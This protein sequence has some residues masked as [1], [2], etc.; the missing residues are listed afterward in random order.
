MNF[1]MEEYRELVER[2]H[3]TMAKSR[4]LAEVR[5]SSDTWTLHD[6]VGHL[7]DSASNNHQRF[8]RLSLADNLEFPGYDAEEWKAASSGYPADYRL[9]VE[10]SLAYNRYLLSLIA[11][12]DETKLGRV[13]HS[14]DGDKTLDFLVRDYFRHLQ[15]HV[16]LFDERL[17]E[18]KNR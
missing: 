1:P 15:W 8:V 13:W 11:S 3:R 17:A 18:I 16:D 12:L 2:F 7:V 9:L 10:L 4:R 14:P 6:M 5:V